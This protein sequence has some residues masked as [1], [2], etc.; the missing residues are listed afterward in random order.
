MHVDVRR[1]AMRHVL[2]YCYSFH[3]VST[4]T[5]CSPCSSCCYFGGLPSTSRDL[6]VS[7][8]PRPSTKS[9]RLSASMAHARSFLKLYS[10]KMYAM[11]GTFHDDPLR[12]DFLFRTPHFRDATL[13]PSRNNSEQE[14]NRGSRLGRPGQ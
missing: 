7:F 1:R 10:D 14:T 3:A 2:S 8:L 4:H 11:H 6:P 5:L 13:V 9:D 12:P